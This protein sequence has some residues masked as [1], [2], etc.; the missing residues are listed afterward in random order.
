MLLLNCERKDKI[1]FPDQIVQSNI[2]KTY[3]INVDS[4][5]VITDLNVH[6]LLMFLLN[7]IARYKAPLLSELIEGNTRSENIALIEKFI[8]TSALKFPKLILAELTGTYFLFEK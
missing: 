4:E 2:G 3:L 1:L 8:Q 6:F 5:K 7:F